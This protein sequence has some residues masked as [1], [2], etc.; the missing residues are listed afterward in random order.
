MS[1]FP[2]TT[3]NGDATLYSLVLPHDLRS[4]S[5]ARRWTAESLD[6]TLHRIPDETLDDVV[7][8]VSELVTNATIHAV[9]PGCTLH[10]L[11]LPPDR[12]KVIV[13]DTDLEH[14][15]VPR[16]AT[17]TDEDGRGLKIVARLAACWGTFHDTVSKETWAQFHFAP[18]DPL[19]LAHAP[20][21]RP[22]LATAEISG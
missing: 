16:V 5:T 8:A 9:G 19:P 21:Q 7:L 6:R 14:R 15:A 10:V 18:E 13:T 22:H 4:P 1:R 20:R 12:I 11:V 17:R 2:N 3:E